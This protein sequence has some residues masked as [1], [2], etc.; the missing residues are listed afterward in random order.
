LLKIGKLPFFKEETD[1]NEI[2][3]SGFKKEMDY[4]Q[5]FSIRFNLGLQIFQP[6]TNPTD[7]NK[8]YLTE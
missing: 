7:R 2:T 1:L 4:N 8:K 6:S 5:I 3:S